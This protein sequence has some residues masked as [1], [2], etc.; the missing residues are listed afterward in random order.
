PAL[1]HSHLRT[2]ML[3]IHQQASLVKRDKEPFKYQIF[4]DFMELVE[5]H[6]KDKHTVA[7]YADLLHVSPK[8]VNAYTRKA[9]DKSAKQFII[10]R[11]VLEIKRYLSTGDMTMSQIAE[12]LGFTE[13]TNMTKF[14]KRYTGMVPSD[15][16]SESMKNQDRGL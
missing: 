5:S 14:F 11:L 7:E 3:Y 15:F 4:M 16:V 13:Q 8:T 9:V 12:E 1:V 2:L 10:D 6:Y